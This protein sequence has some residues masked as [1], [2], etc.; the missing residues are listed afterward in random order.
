MNGSHMVQNW[1]GDGP[2]WQQA[3]WWFVDEKHQII[4]LLNMH[5]AQNLSKLSQLHR[6]NSEKT[7]AFDYFSQRICPSHAI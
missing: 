6:L 2:F 3:S 1:H 7:S 5:I 4:Q